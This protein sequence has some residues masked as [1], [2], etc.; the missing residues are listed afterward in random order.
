M[1]KSKPEVPAAESVYRR[2]ESL[3][4]VQ[5]DENFRQYRNSGEG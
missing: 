4:P 5:P 2:A 3:Q 1:T